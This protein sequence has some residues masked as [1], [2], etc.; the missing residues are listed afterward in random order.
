MCNALEEVQF[1]GLLVC[2][3]LRV[4]DVDSD[5]VRRAVSRSILVVHVGS[6]LGGC[7]TLCKNQMLLM[8]HLELIGAM[9]L[10]THPFYI[11]LRLRW[12]GGGSPTRQN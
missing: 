1:T 2:I 5:G 6:L 8:L 4:W 7:G 12:L 9:D 3:E 10:S 11:L